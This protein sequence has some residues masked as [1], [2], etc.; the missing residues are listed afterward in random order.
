MQA[1]H[2]DPAIFS[3]NGIVTANKSAEAPTV[4]MCQFSLG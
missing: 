1:I 4:M 3:Q 2:A